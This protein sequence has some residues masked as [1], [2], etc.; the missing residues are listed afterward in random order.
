MWWWGKTLV[1]GDTKWICMVREERWQVLRMNKYYNIILIH[2][3]VHGREICQR[4]IEK[5]D[6]WTYLLNLKFERIS[7]DRREKVQRH[8]KFYMA[9][10]LAHFR[11]CSSGW[12]RES[13]VKLKFNRG[14]AFLLFA[15]WFPATLEVVVTS[16]R[17][18]E[19]RHSRRRDSLGKG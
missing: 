4:E 15:E 18:L 2:V 9:G 8:D 17:F 13:W 6:F 12:E 7:W 5:M 1:M 3:C 14:I 10:L 19:S 16:N 11:S